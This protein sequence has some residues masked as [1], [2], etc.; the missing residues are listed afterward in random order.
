MGS[1]LTSPWLTL[2]L[3]SPKRRTRSPRGGRDLN[4]LLASGLGFG[5]GSSPGSYEEAPGTSADVWVGC[6]CSPLVLFSASVVL[7][8]WRLATCDAGVHT[9]GPPED[10][11]PS[12]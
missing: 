1:S 4:I 5:L 2:V 6:R 7:N 8:P 11:V 10:L 12:S 9:P 3:L